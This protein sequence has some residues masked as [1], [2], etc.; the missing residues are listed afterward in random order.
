[1]QRALNHKKETRYAS[2][3]GLEYQAQRLL[4][5]LLL[6]AILVHIADRLTFLKPHGQNQLYR[7]KRNHRF[8]TLLLGS[9]I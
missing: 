4:H 5:G 7:D 8:F 2:L 6:F 9:V 1:M 3:N